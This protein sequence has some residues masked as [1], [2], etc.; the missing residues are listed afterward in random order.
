VRNNFGCNHS[1][2]TAT[3]ID[4]DLLA[5]AGG[6]PLRRQTTEYVTRAARWK[7]DYQPYGLVRIGLRE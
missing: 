6:Q 7:T 2:G 5:Q 1:T 4:D 3:I